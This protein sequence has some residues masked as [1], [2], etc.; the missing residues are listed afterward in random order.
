MHFK[1]EREYLP[2]G[3]LIV[4]AFFVEK[5]VEGFRPSTPRLV[6]DQAVKKTDSVRKHLHS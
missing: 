1:N 2:A 4:R 5:G 6:T 3:L